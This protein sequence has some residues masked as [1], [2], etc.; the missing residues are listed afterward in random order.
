VFDKVYIL[1]HF[2]TLQFT[3]DMWSGSALYAYRVAQ[4]ITRPPLL[5][6]GD[7]LPPNQVCHL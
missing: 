3:A 4:P 2:N 1:F 7:Y 6:C 5:T